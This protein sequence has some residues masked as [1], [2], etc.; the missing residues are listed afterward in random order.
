VLRACLLVIVVGCSHARPQPPTVA[1]ASTVT[2]ES[3]EA[4]YDAKNWSECAAQWTQLAERA[5]GDLK[6]GALYDA[7]CCYAL[8][9][10]AET[11]LTALAAALDAGYWDA[12]HMT[13]DPDLGSVRTDARWPVLAARVQMQY[14]AFAKT[15]VDPALRV[16]LLALAA[17]VEEAGVVGE[18][19]RRMKD[20]VAKHGWPGKRIVGVDGANAAW[21]LVQHADADVAFQAECASKM[22]PLVKIGEVA[23]KDFAF[24]FDRVALAQG[25]PQ[26]Y[27]TQLDGDDIAPLEDPK[28]VDERR[29]SVGLGTLAEYKAVVNTAKP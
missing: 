3:A 10:R 29:R 18:A 15:L 19:T 16:E 6:S 23:G 28:R 26:R 2:A 9:G 25:R 20:A 11:A 7:A 8:D 24:L 12:D 27:G 22:E 17:K 5:S 1:L 13:G 4:A 14:T 21:V